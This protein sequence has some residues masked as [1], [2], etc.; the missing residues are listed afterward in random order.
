MIVITE[1]KT[2]EVDRDEIEHRLCHFGRAGTIRDSAGDCVELA[3]AMELIR[4]KRFVRHSEEEW[5][6][7]DGPHVCG[8]DCV[9]VVIGMSADTQNLLGLQYEAQENMQRSLDMLI[10]DN[11]EQGRE[12]RELHTQKTAIENA[13]WR[14]RLKWLFTGIK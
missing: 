3:D 11:C 2:I 7:Q 1:I 13:S 12:I 14:Q 9:D 5:R 4:G 10:V 6:V 8:D